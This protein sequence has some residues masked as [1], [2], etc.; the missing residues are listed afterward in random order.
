VS[1]TPAAELARLKTQLPLWSIRR[2]A[3]GFTAVN[4]ATGQRV[5]SR[6]LASLEHKLTVERKHP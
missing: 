1:T 4:Q 2:T 6:T 5:Y 3:E